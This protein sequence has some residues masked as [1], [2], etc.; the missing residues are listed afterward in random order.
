MSD[1]HLE[2]HDAPDYL[3]SIGEDLVV[4]A[5]DIGPVTQSV[6]WAQEAFRD[7]QVI[8]VLGNHEHDG[9]EYEETFREARAA[10]KDS[11]VH[12][13][14]KE[15]FDYQSVRVVGCTLWTD[16]DCFGPHQRFAAMLEARQWMPECQEI[17]FGRRHLRPQMVRKISRDSQAWLND[18]IT[19][20]S[21]PVI[22]V[23]HHAPTMHT[24]NPRHEPDLLI[25]SFHNDHPELLRDPVRLWIHGHTHWCTRADVNG[26]PIVSNQRGYPGEHCG[27]FDWSCS[28]DLEH[29]STL[30]LPSRKQDPS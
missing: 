26:R 27:G 28:I 18:V 30:F 6:A 2:S 10:A 17:K 23:T 11:N 24:F 22:V 9:G 1:I 25:A 16:F 19:N 5:G 21:L 4:L 3:P 20:S 13:L 29:P 14:E 8:Y 15:H 12:I 7:R